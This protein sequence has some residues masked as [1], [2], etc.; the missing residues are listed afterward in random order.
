MHRDHRMGA[1]HLAHEHEHVHANVPPALF[2]RE[3][4]EQQYQ[5]RY[6]DGAVAVE[7]NASPSRPQQA[8]SSSSSFGMLL[9]G[10]VLSCCFIA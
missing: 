4:Q 9:D 8:T 1:N 3:Q 2:Q 7:F 5:T 6:Q 10:T